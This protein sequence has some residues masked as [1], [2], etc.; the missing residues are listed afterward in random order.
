M[1]G[2]HCR[3]NR[4]EFEQTVGEI[5]GQGSLLCHSPWGCKELDTTERLNSNKS[6]AVCSQAEGRAC[7]CEFICVQMRP[8][9]GRGR[10]LL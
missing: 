1:V 9:R 5:E 7:G 4:H 8:H 10:K 6:K 3:L 2:W